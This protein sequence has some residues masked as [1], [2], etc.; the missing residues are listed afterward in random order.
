MDM[1]LQLLELLAQLGNRGIKLVDLF[2][3]LAHELHLDV[4]RELGQLLV[5]LVHHLLL[6]LFVLVAVVHNLVDGGL[7]A[8]ENL[9]DRLAIDSHAEE[10][11]ETSKR[12]EGCQKG[13]RGN[14]LHLEP[15]WRRT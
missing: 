2:V 3:D 11:V 4:L 6:G 14:L 12:K 5:K 8:L 13:S 1:H 7:E 15:K 10:S 9:R